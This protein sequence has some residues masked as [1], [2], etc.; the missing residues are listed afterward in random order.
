MNSQGSYDVSKD[1][2]DPQ[3][4]AELEKA[5]AAGVVTAH[6]RVL[7]ACNDNR[8]SRRPVKGAPLRGRAQL[9]LDWPPC[10]LFDGQQRDGVNYVLFARSRGGAHVPAA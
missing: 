1:E 8:R 4:I 2:L 7:C 6:V 5:A 9:A 10:R 3:Q